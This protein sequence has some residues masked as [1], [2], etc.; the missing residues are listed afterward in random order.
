[1][2]KHNIQFKGMRHS[3]SD[4]TGQDGDLLECVNLVHEGGE[5]KPIEMPEKMQMK[6]EF[7]DP[8]THDR[9]QGVLAA[10]HNITDGKK[11]VFVCYE[12]PD[13][14]IWIKKDG[15]NT[16]PVF[17]HTIVSEQVQWVETIGNT[18]IIGTDKSTHYALYK[19]GQ[20]KWLGDKLP[21]PVFDFNI[22]WK[23]GA[24]LYLN[25]Y[26]PNPP[27]KNI[28]GEYIA[29]GG[30]PLS[31]Q[32]DFAYYQGTV[33]YVELENDEAENKRAIRDNFKAKMAELL[34]YAK[35]NNRFVFP[36]FVRYAL[37]L[38][39][40]TYV[41]HSAPLLMLPSTDICPI[42]AYIS[43]F[44]DG[45]VDTSAWWQGNNDHH[46]A[47]ANL[48][49]RFVAQ[50]LSYRN[51]GF[52]DADNH[53]MS[54]S[55]V[56]D[57]SDIIK[58]VDVFLSSE[59]YTYNPNYYDDIENLPTKYYHNP[60][61]QDYGRL[62]IS[63]QESEWYNTHIGGTNPLISYDD[64]FYMGGGTGQHGGDIY[65]NHI[66]PVPSFSKEY[67]MEKI[68]TT[69]VFHKVKSYD[70]HSV[71]SSWNN[72]RFLHEEVEY[73]HLENLE[74]YP[75]LP[76]DFI[77]RSKL[78][79]KVSYNYNQRLV[80]GD[81]DLQAP[82]WY[83]NTLWQEKT[84][85][86]IEMCFVIEKH[87]KTIYVRSDIL[88]NLPETRFG[89]YIYYP[90]P[91]CKEVIIHAFTNNYDAGSYIVPMNEH[92]GLHGAYAV[93]PRL[94]YFIEAMDSYDDYGNRIFEDY[95]GTLPV[96]STDADRYHKLQNTIAMST[97]A[98]PFHFPATNF[99]D[100]GRAKVLGIAANVLDVSSG[101]WGQYPLHIFCSDG[102]IAITI[103]AEGKMGRI[104]AVSADVLKE[105]RGLSQPTLIQTN[106][107]LVFLTQRGVMSISGTK[108]QALSLVMD[109][110][111]FNAMTELADVDYH[112][113]AFANLI[114]RTSDA[115]A[116]RDY[117]ESGFL[118]YDYAHNRVLLLRPD[119]DYQYVL[120]L[121]TMFWSKQIIYTNGESIQIE[122]VPT[123]VLPAERSGGIPLLKVKPMMAA[124]NNYTEL[125]LQC[126]DGF[127][128]KVMDVAGENSVKKIYQYGYFISRPVRLGTDEY[129][130]ITRLLH[131]YTHYAKKSFVKMALYGSRD[132]VKYGRINSLRGMG[133]KYF[134][135]AVYT[136][137][138]PN[139][140][141]S[142]MSVEFE[143][144]LTNKIR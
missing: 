61:S 2:A 124:V 122:E 142:Y 134:I 14:I 76:D 44:Q 110:R 82:L 12:L 45:T 9:Y 80:L 116:F 74:T 133:Y 84:E 6:G 129:K 141:Y 3:P 93:M 51:L 143:P 22:G 55:V 83:K 104:D 29:G 140:R 50:A 65:K 101:Q 91:D 138:K 11:F 131:E 39:D 95:N 71:K 73:G 62:F 113:G 92:L 136:Y 96:S 87:E 117:A 25:Y 34:D 4:I 33:H 24:Q 70:L 107:M 126:T 105:P 112:V 60:I 66:F 37:R 35:K 106:Q 120:S 7:T 88:T 47:V 27:C 121:D 58:G 109:G 100:I 99:K 16:T 75:T 127:L 20:Y 18:L 63:N 53:T 67:I 137:L 135:F 130:T 114:S 46:M 72:Y 31:Y 48:G 49:L 57:W 54:P 15:D 10:V 139:E 81:I 19:N 52:Y 17:V 89:H 69:N 5:L 26:D 123:N 40:N 8:K 68:K 32:S 94:T 125:Y 111:H 79:G 36:F 118:A 85:W 41:M 21:Q 13:S 102:I 128:Y 56:S 90:D 98:N 86:K 43:V 144:R 1:M 59:I 78:A 28:L 119:R 132:G 38:Y 23:Q 30:I 97:V 77:S 42:L 108:P 103:D 115:T 64:T